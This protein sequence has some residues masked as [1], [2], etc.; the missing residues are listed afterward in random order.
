MLEN[1]K[2]RRKLILNFNKAGRVFTFG[3]GSKG[4]LGHGQD[5]QKLKFPESIESFGKTKIL[6]VFCGECHTAFL[7][8]L[9]N[10]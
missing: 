2:W 7:S 8:G 5:L 3:D 1:F 10:V 4:Q 9:L 6:K